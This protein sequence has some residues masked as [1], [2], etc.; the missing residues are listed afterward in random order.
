MFENVK[1]LFVSFR[2]MLQDVI[3]NACAFGIG[4]AIGKIAS[5]AGVPAAKIQSALGNGADFS[6]KSI[7]AGQNDD[8][9]ANRNDYYDDDD[10]KRNDDDKSAQPYDDDKSLMP[11]PATYKETRRNTKK[12]KE[13]I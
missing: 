3:I 11:A 7:G 4:L 13:T 12:T 5:R 6:S 2:P 9:D 1:N 8:D 10:D